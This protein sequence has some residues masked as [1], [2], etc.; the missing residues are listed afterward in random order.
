MRTNLVY[1]RDY[2]KKRMNDE[3]GDNAN[4]LVSSL[5]SIRWKEEKKSGK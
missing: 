4:I 2:N 1:K 5:D 3:T